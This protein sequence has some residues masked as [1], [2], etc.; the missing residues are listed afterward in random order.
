MN[1]FTTMCKVADFLVEK[2]LCQA[3]EESEAAAQIFFMVAEGLGVE[4]NLEDHKPII[5]LAMKIFE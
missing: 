4:P 5:D 3:G 2:G 1:G